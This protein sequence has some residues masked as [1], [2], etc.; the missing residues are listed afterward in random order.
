M[1]RP[2]NLV[3][4]GLRVAAVLAVL[5]P[6]FAMAQ[7]QSDPPPV[8]AGASPGRRESSELK[9]TTNASERPAPGLKA[10]RG[11]GAAKR[12][13]AAAGAAL[14]TQSPPGIDPAL[15]P[16]SLGLCDGS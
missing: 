7:A 6:Q 10:E 16:K 12:S 1:K 5:A 14:R 4:R 2:R 11:S 9:A 3:L 13:P 8:D 15:R